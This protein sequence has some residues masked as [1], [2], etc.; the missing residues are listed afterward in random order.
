MSAGA[1]AGAR[2]G[3]CRSL[4]RPA[5]ASNAWI[6]WPVTRVAVVEYPPEAG[7]GSWAQ[8]S[9]SSFSFVH[10]SARSL[11]FRSGMYLLVIVLRIC[12]NLVEVLV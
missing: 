12:E 5:H 3:V 2:D 1:A 4:R 9:S 8:R 11:G 6:I 7:G 10:V